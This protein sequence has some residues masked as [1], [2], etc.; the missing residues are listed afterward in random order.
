MGPGIVP[1]LRLAGAP[2]H[3]LRR[4]PHARTRAR[5][6]LRP[7]CLRPHELRHTLRCACSLVGADAT[8]DPDAPRTLRGEHLWERKMR[9]RSF[10]VVNAC[11]AYAEVL[12]A[13]GGHMVEQGLTAT[14]IG[15]RIRASAE[16]VNHLL[17]EK[18]LHG[19]PGAYG[20]TEAGKAFGAAVDRDN[21]YGGWAHRSWGWNTWDESV[22]D[23]LGATPQKIADLTA[24]LTAAK[25]AKRV[26]DRIEAEKYWSEVAA[27]KLG[28]VVVDGGGKGGLTNGQKVAIGIGVGVVV[29]GGVVIY[30]GVKRYQRKKA[31]RD[32]TP[33]P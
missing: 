17:L 20:L 19:E 3:P 14:E 13:F 18:G 12:F 2:R 23:E 28:K 24:T 15:R 29:V 27:K 16:V 22:I 7:P 25:A 8:D 10:V 6:R 4:P 11:G 31:A 5:L 33:A 30:K 9:R 21:G 1:F 26:A 32:V